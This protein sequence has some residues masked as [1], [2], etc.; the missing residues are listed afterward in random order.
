[1]RRVSGWALPET[2][3]KVC[4]PAYRAQG[5]NTQTGHLQVDASACLWV[6]RRAPNS[7]FTASYKQS[8]PSCNTFRPIEL[9]CSQQEHRSTKENPYESPP[10][11]DLTLPHCGFDHCIRPRHCGMQELHASSR[12][13]QH[14]LGPPEPYLR[15]QRAKLRTHP[16]LS[17]ERCCDPQR[18]RQQRRCPPARRIGR[19]TGR[20]NPHRRQQ[21]HRAGPASTCS[22][23][24]RPSSGTGEEEARS[25]QEGRLQAHAPTPACSHRARPGSYRCTSSP[26]SS[27]GT[28]AGRS[29]PPTPT[30]L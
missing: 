16:S 20:R 2:A 30:G 24:P 10:R 17:P 5:T 11:L 3:T 27:P 21:P 15:R 26:R 29:C 18:H 7:T 23:S 1:M 9:Q 19:S 8:H 6:A 14:Q 12:R 28:C 25:S 22:S 4:L 13:R